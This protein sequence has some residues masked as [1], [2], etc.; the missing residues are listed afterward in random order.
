M[1]L[2]RVQDVIYKHVYRKIILAW[3]R[4][5]RG[6]IATP[7]VYVMYCRKTITLHACHMEIHLFL[8][9]FLINTVGTWVFNLLPTL[10]L[11]CAEFTHNYIAAFLDHYVRA[12]LARTI[13]IRIN[14]KWILLIN[15]SLSYT[16]V[17]EHAQLNSPQGRR[18]RVLGSG[19]CALLD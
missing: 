16:L 14:S 3:D 9:W 15:S 10:S 5:Y 7:A 13:S 17:K 12:L 2:S 4:S 8:L 1:H 18:T 11:N 6:E 19:T